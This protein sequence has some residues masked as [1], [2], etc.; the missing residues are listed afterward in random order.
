MPLDGIVLLQLQPGQSLE[1]AQLARIGVVADVVAEIVEAEHRLEEKLAAIP[2]EKGAG[3]VVMGQQPYVDPGEEVH[4]QLQGVGFP[5][6][7]EAAASTPLAGR[8][9]AAESA[10]AHRCH[11]G[12]DGLRPIP[13]I[14]QGLHRLAVGAQTIPPAAA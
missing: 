10:Q 11:M 2:G 13:E 8:A 3:V 7:E 1:L 9:K 14:V 6:H 4:Q 12:S 5:G